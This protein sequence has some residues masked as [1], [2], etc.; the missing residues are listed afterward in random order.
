MKKSAS[1]LLI[2]FIICISISGLIACRKTNDKYE[3]LPSNNATLSYNSYDVTFNALKD[4]RKIS[5]FAL[6]PK[7]YQG[8]LPAIIL[9]HG[10]SAIGQ[11]LIYK[12]RSFA[13]LGFASFVYDFCGGSD[14]SKSDGKMSEMT[15]DTEKDD[16]NEILKCV[17]RKKNINKIFLYGESQGG[18]ISTLL[19]SDRP[20]EIAG[21]ILLYPA[22]NGPDAAYRYYETG[23]HILNA[24]T[25]Y[26]ENAYSYYGKMN[27]IFEK[28][29]VKTLIFHGDQ[30]ELVSIDY[31]THAVTRFPD[32]E[33]VMFS[34]SGHGFGREQTE[35]LLQRSESFLSALL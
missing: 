31:S 13:E 1:I 27:E 10:Y 17:K 12:A 3:L 5:G 24:S 19:A 16:L 26:I 33:L 28:C 25:A 30:D 22:F 18:L 35:E 14:H 21:M 4:G 32:A 29:T 7:D 9:S 15:I 23:N 20:K 11:H 34:G 6:V 8:T 2:A